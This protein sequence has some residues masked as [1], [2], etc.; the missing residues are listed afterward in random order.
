MARRETNNRPP[1]DC[2]RITSDFLHRTFIHFGPPGH[3]IHV[4]HPPSPSIFALTHCHRPRPKQ[5]DRSSSAS[6]FIAGLFVLPLAALP[7]HRSPL[8]F[9]GSCT[10]PLSPPAR[11][12]AR[13]S[14]ADLH[15]HLDPF[16]PP[17]HPLGLFSLPTA[18]LFYCNGKGTW[19]CVDSSRSITLLFRPC[20]VPF[21]LVAPCVACWPFFLCVSKPVRQNQGLYNA[22]S[23]QMCTGLCF[24]PCGETKDW[25]FHSLCSMDCVIFCQ[26]FIS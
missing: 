14:S 5:P 21:G 15:C 4:P 13:A 23:A 16:R 19:K 18:W 1:V 10:H 9:S 17:P 8:S 3:P 24:W 2:S 11:P 25:L 12:P 22:W 20:S 26:W 7:N 6:A